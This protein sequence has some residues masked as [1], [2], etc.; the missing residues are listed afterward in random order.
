MLLW[1]LA[2]MTARMEFWV[3]YGSRVQRKGGCEK[4]PLGRD[5]DN[6]K[7]VTPFFWTDPR[8]PNLAIHVGSAE[9]Y[10]GLLAGNW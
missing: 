10:V 1:V 8:I 3:A 2:A 4:S 9:M 7:L 6:R 5:T